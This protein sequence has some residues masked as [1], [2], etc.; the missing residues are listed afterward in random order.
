MAFQS[1]LIH[2]CTIHRKVPDASGNTN[3]YGQPIFSE[4]SASY[5]CRFFKKDKFRQSG[6]LISSDIPHLVVPLSVMLPSDVDIKKE[7]RISTT[8]EGYAGD[9]TVFDIIPIYGRAAI[10]H[11]VANIVKVEP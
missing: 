11:Y 5:Q 2:N 9:Y 3:E 7:D 6:V 10:H 8:T 1:V 4:T